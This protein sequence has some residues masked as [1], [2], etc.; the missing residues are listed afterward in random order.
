MRRRPKKRWLALATFLIALLVAL[1]TVFF[2]AFYTAFGARLLLHSA[3]GWYHR[4]IPGRIHVDKIEGSLAKG[5]SLLSVTAVSEDN[6]PIVDV[7]ELYISVSPANLLLGEIIVPSVKLKGGRVR[8]VEREGRLSM[9]DLIVPS[10]SVEEPPVGPLVP[11]L[12]AHLNIARIVI[13]DVQLIVDEKNTDKPLVQLDAL[14]GKLD[15]KE[16]L[17]VNI[18][19]LD[20]E[21]NVMPEPLQVSMTDTRQ[22]EL[23]SSS[24]STG[25]SIRSKMGTVHIAVQSVLSDALSTRAKLTF[26][27]PALATVLGDTELLPGLNGTLR[28]HG[29]VHFRLDENRG[30]KVDATLMCDQCVVPAMGDVT[31]TADAHLHDMSTS[32]NVEADGGGISLKG[33]YDGELNASGKVS[34]QLDGA[35]SKSVA[36]SLGVD[37]EIDRFS[38]KST[39]ATGDAFFCE[40]AVQLNGAH[41]GNSRIHN[42]QADMN[43]TVEGDVIAVQGD[44]VA[45]GV[46][47]K[48]YD[49]QRL[50]LS[51]A[52]KNDRA[53]L[54]VQLKRRQSESANINATILF[55]DTVT[56]QIDELK[57]TLMGVQVEAQQPFSLRIRDK[58][59]WDASTAVLKVNRT[60]V[61]FEKL[62]RNGLELTGDVSFENL[63]LQ[64]VGALL[65]KPMGGTAAGRILIG[66]ASLNPD[67]SLEL[68]VTNLSLNNISLDSLS[69]KARLSNGALSFDM[70]AI[71]HDEPVVEM[72]G[73]A[74]VLMN[75][76]TFEFKVYETKPQ[77]VEWTLHQ[78]S[79]Q[80]FAGWVSLPEKL[81]FRFDA[82][83]M[84]TREGQE[85]E[86]KNTMAVALS[87]PATG[88]M[89][90]SMQ[91]RMQRQRQHLELDATDGFG[92]P[93]QMQLDADFPVNA[94][95]KG[96]PPIGKVNMTA[97]VDGSRV[98]ASIQ[99]RP[100]SQLDVSLDLESLSVPLMASYVGWGD[101]PLEGAVSGN[102]KWSMDTQTLAISP[103][104]G[105][106]WRL[107]WELRHI[108]HT[109]VQKLG[110]TIEPVMFDTG[111]SG[112]VVY[113]GTDIRAAGD[114]DG[115]V[116]HGLFLRF[117]AQ[118]H[119]ELSRER[120]DLR[121][122]WMMP[123]G[124]PAS[125]TV[126][127]A[128]DLVH[129]LQ[130]KF[131]IPSYQ[132]QLRWGDIQLALDGYL[133]DMQ[134]G[135]LR[136][137]ADNVRLSSL[138][139]FLQTDKVD[140]TLDLNVD[141]QL[142][143]GQVQG[144]CNV[145][146][147]AVT[148]ENWRL[149][150]AQLKATFKDDKL[151]V[152]LVG[153][154]PYGDDITL[155]ASI[156]IHIDAPAGTV[157]WQRLEPHRLQWQIPGMGLYPFRQL[158]KLPDV[159]DIRLESKGNVTGNADAFWASVS[160][161]GMVQTPGAISVP[162][163]MDVH[164]RP[165]KQDA[166]LS[167]SFDNENRFIL[168]ANAIGHIPSIVAG[169]TDWRDV[170]FEATLR[171]GRFDLRLLELMPFPVV[172]RPDGEL[173]ARADIKGTAN[174]PDFSGS[175]KIR[176][177]RFAIAGLA[178]Q[179]QKLY[180][181]IKLHNNSLSVPKMRFRSG[182]GNG[183]FSGKVAA[184]KGV[185]KGKGNLK[186]SRFP[187]AT[188]GLPRFVADL[189]SHFRFEAT[190]N[191]FDAEVEL[192]KT[193]F[194]KPAE[195]RNTMR[196]VPSNSNVTVRNSGDPTDAE[197]PGM[198]YRIQLLSR[199]PITVTGKDMD[200]RWNMNLLFGRTDGLG[201]IGGDIRSERGRFTL[202][203]SNF[204]L[205]KGQLTLASTP[206]M[207]AY[208]QLESSSNISSYTVN[209]NVTGNLMH[210][211]LHLSSSPLLSEEQ[212]L[213][214]LVSGSAEEDAET[215]TG[216]I[217]TLLSVQYPGIH[218]LLYNKFGIS[219][220]RVE[221]TDQGSTALK[222]GKRVTKRSTVYTVMNT[223]PAK[224]ENEYEIQVET[225]V[226]DK[227]S[228][229]SAFGERASSIGMYRRIPIPNKKSKRLEK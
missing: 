47:A 122:E 97:D 26:D 145:E 175:I 3:L 195:S 36:G 46:H 16:Q 119:Y 229:G 4:E 172:S 211:K 131:T 198:D 5:L 136:A 163:Q 199:D 35:L 77:R 70:N 88:D 39:C 137:R 86:L 222:A 152:S 149:D 78:I 83:G 144:S 197:S 188:S 7:A 55:S 116:G 63:A 6:E 12:G 151:R 82:D 224:N 142:H 143:D 103:I 176:N 34:L 8:L 228:V 87:H 49:F 17:R 165:D 157:Q 21:L 135:E 213:S 90:V 59:Y 111:F 118:L 102:V 45:R 226:T 179:I 48:K 100:E 96:K 148:G 164:I 194:T 178:N 68:D 205:H 180:G 221:T 160:F 91:T 121:A 13:D 227:T 140:A 181:D 43:G 104:A 161:L 74:S 147:S 42:L 11:S 186:L 30:P 37:A 129:L 150:L 223:N 162:W 185:W 76:D 206:H 58:D 114:L 81:S 138:K 196:F 167:M 50:R 72:N 9:A 177:G 75:L 112:S 139:P 156:P 192:L 23:K 62:A 133:N 80:D 109:L 189:I 110:M 40:S 158:L 56:V 1:A 169:K 92:R 95:L 22:I 65:E 25:F 170:P 31:M 220:L 14:H 191:K 159:F 71:R 44:V 54:T 187:V 154:H 66:G 113:D 166:Q 18:S 67:V 99:V 217:T 155:S 126:G 57:S 208:V 130:G 15:W 51:G 212:I 210:P 108:S 20:G 174:S 124:V 27:V 52:F 117:P 84:L 168:K 41:F 60:P 218:N 200:T 141:V 202:F 73:I 85:I 19:R 204:T 115:W 153:Q 10:D 64:D 28:G 125:F 128:M 132:A 32:V 215:S 61:R 201:S 2:V 171:S 89:S 146:A 24:V 183:A 127:A 203:Q 207:T 53:K 134:N 101:T 120:Q 184:L 69:T 106:P 105:E 79:S 38:V 123:N 94:L 93:I 107:S 182:R 173:Y 209:L 214:L 33:K 219:Q 193:T 225:S 216:A 190:A 29:D 98:G